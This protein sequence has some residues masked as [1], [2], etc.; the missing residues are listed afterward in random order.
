MFTVKTVKMG[1][2]SK[3]ISGLRIGKP[4]IQKA[5]KYFTATE[6]ELIVQEFLASDCSKKEIWKKYTGQEEEHGQLLRWIW[7]LGY[8]PSV[9]GRRSNF[10]TINEVSMKKN[11]KPVP[12]SV[13]D[14]ETLQLKKRIS[15]LEL[16]LNDAEM[17][18]IAF[19]TMIDIAERELHVPIRKKY[20]TKSSKK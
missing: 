4:V 5:G 7:Q 11:S 13:E 2:K 17:K 19:S 14:F 18:A 6:R 8:D 15:E 16:Q 3:H 10:A 9:K 1:I 12:P 20:N